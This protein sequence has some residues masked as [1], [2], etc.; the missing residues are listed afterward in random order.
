MPPHTRQARKTHPDTAEAR[1]GKH[2]QR[3]DL[4]C[5]LPGAVTG[6]G[7]PVTRL[8]PAPRPSAS[9]AKLSWK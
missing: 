7:D 5:F 8:A 6:S 9:G 1:A 4:S 2:G 3:G